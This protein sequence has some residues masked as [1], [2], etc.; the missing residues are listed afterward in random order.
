MHIPFHNWCIHFG[1]TTWCDY[2]FSIQAFHLTPTLAWNNWRPDA[3]FGSLGSP[4]LYWIILVWLLLLSKLCVKFMEKLFNLPIF[5]HKIIC[6]ASKFI[7]EIL[8]LL[9]ILQVRVHKEG[10]FYP[11]YIQRAIWTT[12]NLMVIVI[13]AQLARKISLAIHTNKSIMFLFFISYT[14]CSYLHFHFYVDSYQHCLLNPPP[15]LSVYVIGNN[16]GE[17]IYRPHFCTYT[18]FLQNDNLTSIFNKCTL[19]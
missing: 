5:F 3:N 15:F 8:E 16:V 9:C 19:Y 12:L 6:N 13:D 11:I 14:T 18:K 2:N 4:N 17:A 10:N 7:F 1:W